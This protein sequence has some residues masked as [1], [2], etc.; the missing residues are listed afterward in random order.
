MI[1][2]F[3]LDQT[4]VD[5]SIAEEFRKK[6]SWPTVF[7]LIPWFS[8]YKGIDEI[9]QLL[10]SHNVLWSIVTNSPEIYAEKVI[11][12]FNIEC[13]NLVGYY[14][15]KRR[16]KPDTTGLRVSLEK[17]KIKNQR[18]EKIIGVGD[19]ATDI[20][21]YKKMGMTS[22]LSTWG[23]DSKIVSSSIDADYVFN[24]T[25]DLLKLLKDNLS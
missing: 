13:D 3:D 1:V 15:S 24:S 12:H 25:S 7:K 16:P 11:T 5:T 9:L 10:K 18:N 8:P 6:R 17:M 19:L 22:V 20:I 21:A 2:I 23:S 4:L 14:E